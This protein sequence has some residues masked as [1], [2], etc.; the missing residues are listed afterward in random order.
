MTDAYAKM[1]KGGAGDKPAILIAPSWHVEIVCLLSK[2]HEAKHH[3][4]VT[5]GMDE[6]DVTVAESKVK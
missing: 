4:K 6:L 3:V 2:R 1:E 5:L